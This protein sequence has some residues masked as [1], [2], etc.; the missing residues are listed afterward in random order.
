MKQYIAKRIGYAAIS[1]VLL[2]VII[3]P[4]EHP[5][6]EHSGEIGMQPLDA[7]HGATT[8]GEQRRD[9]IRVE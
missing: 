9:L 8:R 7:L 5:S 3:F 4:F 6:D 1:L 2:S